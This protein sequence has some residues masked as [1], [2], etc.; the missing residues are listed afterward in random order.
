MKSR[1][2][3]ELDLQLMLDNFQ[4]SLCDGVSMLSGSDL[5]I[6]KGRIMELWDKYEH[7]DEELDFMLENDSLAG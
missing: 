6:L 2:C 1:S 3:F 5:H 4:M 7:Y